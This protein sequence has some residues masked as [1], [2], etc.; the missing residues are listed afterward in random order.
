MSQADSWLFT[1]VVPYSML[2][3]FPALRQGL[4]F[5]NFSTRLKEEALSNIAD[6]RCDK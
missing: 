4:L 5:G 2:H 3:I 1:F 6:M